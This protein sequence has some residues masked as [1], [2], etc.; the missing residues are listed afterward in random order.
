MFAT[1][2]LES[3]RA[4]DMTQD[5]VL[6]KAVEIAGDGEP[7]LSKSTLNR[8][9]GGKTLVAKPS[10]LR[11]FCRITGADI[12]EAL[13]ALGYVTRDELDLPPAPSVDPLA[14][15]VSRL[16]AHPE[17]RPEAKA[18]LRRILESA[19]SFTAAS[20]GKVVGRRPRTSTPAPKA[21]RTR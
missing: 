17:I 1:W 6:S 7:E 9:E 14:F 16:L 11:V 2:V 13:I 4:A 5:D 15:E 10:N 8:W 21:T 20:L 18:D 12:R 19:V 3:R